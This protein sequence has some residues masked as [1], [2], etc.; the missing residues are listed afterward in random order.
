MN[1]HDEDCDDVDDGKSDGKLAEEIEAELS[2]HPALR[3]S[4]YRSS[5]SSSERRGVDEDEKKK[6]K[7]GG[8]DALHHRSR[9]VDRANDE[10]G[11]LSPLDVDYNMVKSLID[12]VIAEEG[13]PGPASNLIKALGIDLDDLSMGGNARDDDDITNAAGQ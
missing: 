10:N 4:F 5:S 9:E 1:E 6:T 3:Q 8:T 2:E 7:E 11:E 13:M 12:S